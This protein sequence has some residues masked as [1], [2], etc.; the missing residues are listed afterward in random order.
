MA[1]RVQYENSNDIGVFSKLTNG[2]CLVAA[3]GS[4][5]FYSVFESELGSFIPVIQATI[6]GTRIVGRTTAGTYKTKIQ[7]TRKD[8][9]FPTTQQTTNSVTSETVY[10][11]M[12]RSFELSRNY[13]HW[14][15]VSHAT[16]TSPWFIPTSTKKHRKS[17]LTLWVLKFLEI[18]SLTICSSELTVSLVTMEVWFTHKLQLNSWINCQTC[19]KSPC[20][21]VPSTEGLMLSVLVWSW[22]IGLHSVDWNQPPLKFKSLRAFS[23]LRVTILWKKK[24]EYLNE[25]KFYIFYFY[26]FPR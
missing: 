21:L 22:T 17:S 7:A 14:A 10:H 5:N 13:P 16:I 6:G 2:Y 1:N 11:K 8:C 20:V 9:S 25:M 23:S 18:P 19:F 3:G 26:H 24:T 4:Y 15:T 12:W